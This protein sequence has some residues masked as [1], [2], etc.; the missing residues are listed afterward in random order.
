MVLLGILA[1]LR[2]QSP[3]TARPQARDVAQLPEDLGPHWDDL[4]K[5]YKISQDG[6]NGN[7]DYLQMVRC[8]LYGFQTWLSRI[9]FFTKELVDKDLKLVEMMVD[10]F[11]RIGRKYWNLNLLRHHLQCRWEALASLEKAGVPQAM[12]ELWE[13]RITDGTSKLAEQPT[14]TLQNLCKLIQNAMEDWENVKRRDNWCGEFCLPLWELRKS[15]G[16]GPPERPV[17]YIR[18]YDKAFED[19]RV[20]QAEAQKIIAGRLAAVADHHPEV[21]TE[22]DTSE[23]KREL[24]EMKVANEHLKLQVAKMEE[25][26]TKIQQDMLQYQDAFDHQQHMKGEVAD[27]KN[28]NCRMKE[29][30]ADMK[31]ENNRFKQKEKQVEQKVKE[32]EQDVSSTKEVNEKQQDELLGIKEELG[33]LQNE[34]F[35][36]KEEL[37]EL[38]LQNESIKSQG[39]EVVGRVDQLE[40]NDTFLSKQLHDQLQ[41]LE[42]ERLRMKE[43]LVDFKSDKL[44]VKEELQELKLKLHENLKIKGIESGSKDQQGSVLEYVTRALNDLSMQCQ[45]LQL[46]EIAKTEVSECCSEVSWIQVHQDGKSNMLRSA[47]SAFSVETNGPRCFMLDAMFKTPSGAFLSGAD[48]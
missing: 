20:I 34:N 21:T 44:K 35:K 12:K 1:I 30:L 8:D 27:L 47:S 18:V 38:K 41:K 6:H 4:N 43:E 23:V 10:H 29:E 28:D 14:S 13:T 17:D 46:N 7:H 45:R 48:L 31:S 22:N 11:S 9:T 2:G 37:Q 42:D 5:R 3:V 16:R 26:S 25:K 15:R 33:Q 36:M 40:E 32:L 19:F 24:Q 39:M